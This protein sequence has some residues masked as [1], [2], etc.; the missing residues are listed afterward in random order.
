MTQ[1]SPS[2]GGTSRQ[3]VRIGPVWRIPER[4]HSLSSLRSFAISSGSA[5]MLG[6]S[7]ASAATKPSAGETGARR[8]D[9]GAGRSRR[10]A[11]AE[12]ATLSTTAGIISD[13]IR[14]GSRPSRDPSRASERQ[15][16]G[17]DSARRRMRSASSSSGAGSQR[18]TVPP[19]TSTLIPGRTRPRAARS[20]PSSAAR[21]RARTELPTTTPGIDSPD[22]VRS[23]S[24]ARPG[25]NRSVVTRHGISRGLARDVGKRGIR[26]LGDAFGRPPAVGRRSVASAAMLWSLNAPS[27]SRRRVVFAA[28]G[29]RGALDARASGESP[30]RRRVARSPSSAQRDRDVADQR[31]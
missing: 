19:L 16:G 17:S 29:C 5:S 24:T 15:S 20:S 4:C 3:H 6:S 28:K 30:R 12:R 8:R 13:R 10:P 23:A 7:E 14:A 11:S 22:K 2:S 21:A 27:A 18:A 26:R 31:A 1:M 9:E 25:S